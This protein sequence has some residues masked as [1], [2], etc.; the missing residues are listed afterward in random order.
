MKKQPLHKVI[1][2]VFLMLFFTKLT[3]QEETLVYY[4]DE[5]Q[6]GVS[7]EAFATYKAIIANPVDTNFEKQYVIKYLPNGKTIHEGVYYSVDKYAIKNWNMKSYKSYDL[8]GNLAATKEGDSTKFVQTTYYLNGKK[9]SVGTWVNGKI[10]GDLFMYDE[11]DDIVSI[12][13]Y[14]MGEEQS[15]LDYYNKGVHTQYKTTKEDTRGKLILEDVDISD[16]TEVK[17]SQGVS[18]QKYVKNGLILQSSCVKGNEYS[19]HWTIQFI[20]NN[21]ARDFVRIEEDALNIYGV[22]NGQRV[23]MKRIP[24]KTYMKKVTR[25]HATRQFWMGFAEGF[26]NAD[27]GKHTSN[28]RVNVNGKNY[29]IE[30]TYYD[31]YEWNEAQNKSKAR[32]D[33]YNNYLLEEREEIAD[34]Y[35]RPRPINPDKP[36]FCVLCLELIDVD[37]I[38]AE[39]TISNRKY[40]YDWNVKL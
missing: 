36:V 6:K 28:A 40:Q 16:R 20:F 29:H 17:D 10:D 26:V 35:Y 38:H 24:L 32:L 8:D 37:E 30:T 9:E 34:D 13:H 33:A 23:E 22:K 4:Y 21:L 7:S 19:K 27:A 14:N 25:K 2:M 18:W 1:D 15:P 31:Q 11:N 39:L 12:W 5:N 3:A